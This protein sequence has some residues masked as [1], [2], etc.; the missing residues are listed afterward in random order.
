MTRFLHDEAK[1]FPLWSALLLMVLAFTAWLMPE[2]DPLAR[3]AVVYGG[4]ISAG[5]SFSGFA[6]VV[7]STRIDAE[8][9]IRIFIGG[10]IARLALALAAIAAG[11][12]LLDF[13]VA[14]LIISCLISYFVFTLLEYIFLLPLLTEKLRQNAHD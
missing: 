4:L 3:L 8:N 2:K 10:M 7:R 9:F 14:M 11:I 1:G 13:P 12:A 5:I 6:L